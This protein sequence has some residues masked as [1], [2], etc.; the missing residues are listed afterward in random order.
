LE[1]KMEDIIEVAYRKPTKKNF[2]F[3]ID[4]YE[5]RLGVSYIDNVFAYVKGCKIVD[6]YTVAEFEPDEKLMRDVEGQINIKESAVKKF[7]SGIV[8]EM[9]ALRKLGITKWDGCF[10]VRVA[11]KRK[12]QKDFKIMRTPKDVI[13]AEFEVRY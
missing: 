4:F 11:V 3:D 10:D 1:D 7:R 6:P 13:D 5:N 2:D 8:G 12:V 9:E